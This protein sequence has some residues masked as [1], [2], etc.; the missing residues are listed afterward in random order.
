MFLALALLNNIIAGDVEH[1]RRRNH[2]H[3]DRADFPVKWRGRGREG[4]EY[5]RNLMHCNVS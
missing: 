3:T 4:V 5:D 1:T 2:T